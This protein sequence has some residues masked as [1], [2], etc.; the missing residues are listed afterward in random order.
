MQDQ[1]AEPMQPARRERPSTHAE[2]Q[3]FR[4]E[5]LILAT[6]EVLAR[7]GI[8]NATVSAICSA[9]GASRGLINHYYDSKEA[10]FVDTYQYLHDTLLGATREAARATSGRP[11]D[12]LLAII[13]A[14][15]DPTKIGIPMRSAYLVFWTASLTNPRYREM[16]RKQHFDLHQNLT[17]LFRKA[18]V[19]RNLELDAAQAATGLLG[20]VDGLWLEMS[21]AMTDLDTEAALAVSVDYIEK[22]L[23]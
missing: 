3:E 22:Q 8:E 16:N 10:L 2:I 15:F 1:P 4:R 19:E 11:Y 12:Q 18:A 5:S 21:I 9:A 13:R 7:H 20:L 23:C 6:I 17:R 14:A